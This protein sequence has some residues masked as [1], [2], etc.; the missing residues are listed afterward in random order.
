[1]EEKKDKPEEKK[2]KIEEKKPKLEEKLEDQERRQARRKRRIRN[3]ILAYLTVLIFISLV[4][5]GVLYGMKWFTREQPADKES[6]SEIE[7]VE[8]S[9][10]ETPSEESSESSEFFEESTESVPEGPTAEERL[11]ALIDS[12]IEN[13][14]LEDK[15]AG[16]FLVTPESITGVST[17]VKAGDGTKTALEK[18]AVR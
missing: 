18:Y 17:A 7:I 14:T 8:S 4:A 1:M 16:L 3:Q 9:L 10:P 2:D 15:V 5:G 13:M 12:V 6:S 11:E